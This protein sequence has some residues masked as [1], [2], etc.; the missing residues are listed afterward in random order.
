M[1]TMAFA[2]PI[3]AGKTDHLFDHL[4]ENFSKEFHDHVAGHG[5]THIRMYHQTAPQEALIVYLEGPDL[6]K[7]IE[8]MYHDPWSA[9]WF[10]TIGKMGGHTKEGVGIQPA[11]L[12]MDWH[13]EEGHRHKHQRPAK[14]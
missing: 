4:E 13:H 11:Q 1:A 5:M 12:V 14:K 9:R 7:T 6:E 10:E 2:L 8:A 3:E